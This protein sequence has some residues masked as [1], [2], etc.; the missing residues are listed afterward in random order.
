LSLLLVEDS[1]TTR[2]QEKRILEASGYAVVT[3]VDGLDGWAK[4]AADAFD[5]VITDI[6]MPN[7]DGLALAAKIRQDNRYKEMP[8]I[9][10]TSMAS[11]ED[12]RK[13]IEVGANAYI[14]KSSFDQ[15]VL[16]DTVRRLV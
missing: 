13:G 16:L 10:V 11:D 12:K 8:I 2:T 1:I 5:A 14:T 3:A 15:Q 6:Q 4:L 7:M 9:L